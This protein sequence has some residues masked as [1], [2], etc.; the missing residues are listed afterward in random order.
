MCIPCLFFIV[1]IP[2]ADEIPPAI[3]T[4]NHAQNEVTGDTGGIGGISLEDRPQKSLGL[5]F[6]KTV[7]SKGVTFYFCPHC[8]HVENIH[9]EVIAHHIKYSHTT[10]TDIENASK[11]EGTGTTNQACSGL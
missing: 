2:P 9:P 11:T 10:L 3:Y 6:K 1:P 7:T 5:S 4:E 8:P